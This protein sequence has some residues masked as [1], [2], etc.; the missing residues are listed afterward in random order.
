M[1]ITITYFGQARTLAGTRT[2]VVEVP[3]EATLQVAVGRVAGTHGEPFDR[4]VFD[5][6][7][8]PKRSV[9]LAVNDAVPPPGAAAALKD[10]D[11]ISVQTAIAGR[12][13]R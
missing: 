7:G 1:K 4:L 8:S 12:F 5:A 9:L 11:E 10:G 6:D 2:E 13:T 3:D